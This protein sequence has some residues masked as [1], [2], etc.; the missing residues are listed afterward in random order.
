M[1]Y[2]YSGSCFVDNANKH[3]LRNGYCVRLLSVYSLFMETG[4]WVLGDGNGA[5]LRS[6]VYRMLLWMDVG[7]C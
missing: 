5:V 7:A 4:L 2:C 1:V 6:D 3:Y